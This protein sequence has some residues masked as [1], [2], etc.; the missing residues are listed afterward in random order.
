MRILEDSSIEENLIKSIICIR[1]CSIENRIILANKLHEYA[2][3]KVMESVREL[4]ISIENYARYGTSR[5]E[6]KI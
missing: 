1:F 4:I 2:D 5:L 3:L 6:E